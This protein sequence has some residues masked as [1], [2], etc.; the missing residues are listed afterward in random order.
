M[1]ETTSIRFTDGLLGRTVLFGVL[2]TAAVLAG[3]ILVGGI[4]RYDSL[5]RGAEDRLRSVATE[6]SLDLDRT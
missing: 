4:S 6:A 5:K 3:V 1:G 2:P